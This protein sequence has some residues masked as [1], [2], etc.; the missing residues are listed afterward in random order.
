MALVDL[1]P[2]EIE[3][4]VAREEMELAEVP[5]REE[6]LLRATGPVRTKLGDKLRSALDQPESASLV[7]ELVEALEEAIQFG[8]EGWAYASD[9][10]REKWEYERERANLRAVLLKAQSSLGVK[11]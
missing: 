7:E 10:F 9:Y 4:L 8:D 3:R 11:G 2:K 6:S 5:G 1:T